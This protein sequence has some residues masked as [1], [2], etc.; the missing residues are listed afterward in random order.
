MADP[1]T[2]DDTEE[3]K[4]ERDFGD[5]A[6]GLLALLGID[7]LDEDEDSIVIGEPSD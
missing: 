6:L 2:T 5:L 3:T 4:D 1:T 7:P